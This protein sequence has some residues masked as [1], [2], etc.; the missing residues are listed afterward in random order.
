[1]IR[2]SLCALTFSTIGFAGIPT[3]A[4]ADPLEDAINVLR[5]IWPFGEEQEKVDE[6]AVNYMAAT[7]F[8]EARGEGDVGMRAVAHVIVNRA[9]HG[10][11]G[12]WSV[13]DVVTSPWQF[14]PWNGGFR[15]PVIRNQWQQDRWDEAVQ[16]S[17]EVLSGQSVDPT[18]GAL[19]FHATYVRPRW[20]RGATGRTRIGNHI[21]YQRAGGRPIE[22]IPMPT[23]EAVA[24]EAAPKSEET[25]PMLASFS[26][27]GPNRFFYFEEPQTSY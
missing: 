25:E 17:R 10:G 7:L 24:V 11:Y 22:P 13:Y 14:S 15:Q 6:E 8:M 18:N 27:D 1:M 23:T 2:T 16:I 26:L 4:Y 12:G 5:D 19:Y 20:S 3:P 9:N 21:F